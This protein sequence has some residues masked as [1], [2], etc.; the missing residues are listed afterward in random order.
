MMHKAAA[1]VNDLTGAAPCSRAGRAT[2]AE[3]T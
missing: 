1:R 2:R 3:F